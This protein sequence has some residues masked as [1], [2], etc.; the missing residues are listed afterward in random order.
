MLP[1]KRVHRTL[2][3]H[4]SHERDVVP[5]LEMLSDAQTSRVSEDD[6][7]ELGAH[8]GE[9]EKNGSVSLFDEVCFVE[10]DSGRPSRFTPP[11]AKEILSRHNIPVVSLDNETSSEASGSLGYGSGAWQRTMEQV[12]YFGYFHTFEFIKHLTPVAS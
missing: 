7:G 1:R 12:T 6:H 10:I 3:F 11:T 2:W 4:A 8:H 5:L 9:D